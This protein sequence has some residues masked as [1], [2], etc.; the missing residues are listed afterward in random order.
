MGARPNSSPVT[1]FIMIVSIMVNIECQFCYTHKER[2]RVNN[3][4]TET[5][6]NKKYVSSRGRVAKK[7]ATGHL[8]SPFSPQYFFLKKCTIFFYQKN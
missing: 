1:L 5:K 6:L 3:T 7:G 4:Y 2:V 8:F